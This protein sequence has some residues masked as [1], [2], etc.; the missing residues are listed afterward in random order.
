VTGVTAA[1]GSQ[2][3]ADTDVLIVGAGPSGLLAAVELARHVSRHASSNANRN[4]LGRRA[5]AIQPGTLEILYQTG[6]LGEILPASVHLRFARLFDRE[7]RQTA[8]TAFADADAGCPWNFQCSLPQ[9]RTE[10]I[11]AERLAE[12]GGCVERGVEVVSLRARDDSVLADLKCPDG[13]AET[14]QARWVVGAGGAHSVTRESM[15]GNL[16]GET[17]PGTALVADVAVS[18]A[19]PRDGSA[20][21]ATPAGYVMLAPLPNERWITFIGDL[22]GDEAERLTRDTS[23]NAVAATMARRIPDALVELTDVEWAASFRMHKR[24]TSYLADGRRFLLG[25]AGHLSSPFG[26]E[27]LNSGLHDTHNLAWKLVLE[28]AGR[29]RP[30]LLDTYAI[31][32]TAAARRVLAVSDG[33]HELAHAAVTA[34]RHGGQAPVRQPPPSRERTAALVR[35]RCML[36][37]SYADSPLTGHYQARSTA[38]N[39]VPGPGERYPGRS[40]LRGTG[41][42]LLLS[43]PRDETALARL[44]CKWA[45]LVA[46][47]ADALQSGNGV[48]LVRPDGYL[49]FCA[50]ADAAPAWPRSTLT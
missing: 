24:M 15:A 11:L 7:L 16:A 34:A 46:V 30:S 27:G 13:T 20:L 29:A 12:F 45:G 1:T 32:R 35:A 23:M 37:V 47:G 49:G 38:D 31:E 39:P 3:A 14:A 21:I 6:L 2:T 5:T 36:D 10:Q 50:A 44:H 9:W 17:Y 42:H 19:L 28:V 41:H 40:A 33:L 8:E 25:D 22:D 48:A 18:A 43:G 26:G 4:R